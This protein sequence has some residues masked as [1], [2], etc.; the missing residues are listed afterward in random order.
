M[1]E[2]RFIRLIQT[3][4]QEKVKYAITGGVAVGLWGFLRATKDIDLILDFSKP[5]IKKLIKAISVLGL[6]PYVPEN[7]IGLADKNKRDFWMQEKNAKVFSFIH[8]NDMFFRVDIMLNIELKDVIVNWKEDKDIKIPVV[9]LNDLFLQKLQ[10]KRFQD[11]QDI[12]QLSIIHPQI[13][14]ILEQL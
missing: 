9:G 3:L 14:K 7:P 1:V 2:S 5:N 6:K 10:A 11:M 4:N 8:P 13:I 12:T